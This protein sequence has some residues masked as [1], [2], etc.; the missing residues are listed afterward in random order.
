[1]K[2]KEFREQLLQLI[3]SIRI[4]GPQGPP[5]PTGPQG[6]TGERGLQ[7]PQGIPGPLDA[8]NYELAEQ[9]AW[10]KNEVAVMKAE[11]DHNTKPRPGQE[12]RKFRENQ[13]LQTK[14]RSRGRR[15]V[16]GGSV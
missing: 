15:V 10:L 11:I 5:G 3:A 7:G 9:F 2:K 1:M 8:T 16:D 12:V 6:P 14:K 4:H 13:R